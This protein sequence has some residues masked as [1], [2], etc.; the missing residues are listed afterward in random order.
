[1]S[2]GWCHP[3]RS[4]L[5]LGWAQLRNRLWVTEWPRKSRALV[6]TEWG[7]L[8]ICL[9]PSKLHSC[10]AWR[11]RRIEVV[12]AD[13]E[14]GLFTYK[15]GGRPIWLESYKLEA[16]KVQ[17]WTK[18]L[19]PLWYREVNG[20]GQAKCLKTIGKGALSIIV[21]GRSGPCLLN[22]EREKRNTGCKC[23]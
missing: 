19:W 2:A 3:Q 1:M 14:G 11:L 10:F 13:L 6:C 4:F 22:G 12:S 15:G 8:V 7:F 20:I 9:Q 21:Y 17:D 23:L 18:E 5:L 16:E